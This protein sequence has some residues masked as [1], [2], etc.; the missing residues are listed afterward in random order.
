MIC[1]LVRAFVVLQ[2]WLFLSFSLL[3]KYEGVNEVENAA[4]RLALVLLLFYEHRSENADFVEIL[5]KKFSFPGSSIRT[6]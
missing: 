6:T 4:L 3:Y 2:P 1:S 5:L